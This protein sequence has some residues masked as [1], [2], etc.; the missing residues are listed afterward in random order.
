MISEEDLVWKPK[1]GKYEN[2]L[3]LV[4]GKWTVGSIFYDSARS[5]NDPKKYAAN[6]HLPGI[7]S[8][9]DYWDT[10]EEAK[11]RVVLAV[12]RWFQ[13]LLSEP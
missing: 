10:E 4:V 2:G 8:R 6:I 13:G 7:L 9:L 11:A 5:R 12:K 1:T 3:N